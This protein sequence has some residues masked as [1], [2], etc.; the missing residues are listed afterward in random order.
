MCNLQM[1]A[2]QL[3]R[4]EINEVINIEEIPSKDCVM[5]CDICL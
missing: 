2:I 3:S 5:L 1:H 4:T